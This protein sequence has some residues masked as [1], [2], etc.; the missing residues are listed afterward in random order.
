MASGRE[1]L[2]VLGLED[3][4]AARRARAG[5][6]RDDDVALLADALAARSPTALAVV[7]LRRGE[8]RRA[9]S[10]TS[11]S[12]VR[13]LAVPR[14]ASAATSSSR[15]FSARR[16]STI[17]AQLA[18]ASRSS[19]RSCVGLRARRSGASRRASSSGTSPAG[20]SSPSEEN[21]LRRSSRICT[22]T[23]PSTDLTRFCTAT[24]DSSP[25]WRASALV[26]WPFSGP[27]TSSSSRRGARRPGGRARRTRCRARARLFSNS[28]LT[29][30]ALAPVCSRSSTRAPISIASATRRRSSPASSRSAARRTAVSSSTTRPSIAEASAARRGPGRRGDGVAA[31]IGI[32]SHG[33]G[34]T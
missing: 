8:R 17:L 18:P 19:S 32:R 2:R 20:C 26:T 15:S 3:D 33:K 4:P 34:R 30:S 27:K 23:S 5:V 25:K 28:A 10:A 16:R 6:D 22:L 24:D 29:N 12:Y 7:A 11:S 31:S 1:R 21:C 9:P 14:S 13:P